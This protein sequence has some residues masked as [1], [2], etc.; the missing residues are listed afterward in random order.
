MRSPLS[1]LPVGPV[2][3]AALAV[4]AS[5]ACGNHAPPA[6]GPGGGSGPA[7]D[8][9]RVQLPPAAPSAAPVPAGPLA[10]DPSTLVVH[11]EV[12]LAAVR[13]NLEAKV[14]RRVAEEK[15][16][17]IGA[18]GRLEYT[19]DRGPFTASIQGDALVLETPLHGHARACA[20]GRCYAGCDPEMKAVAR[21]PLRLGADYKFRPSAVRVDVVRGCEVRALGGLVTVDAT[22][23]LRSKL[24]QESRRIEQQIDREL[25]DLRPEAERLWGALGKVQTLPLGACA[26]VRPEGVVQGPPGGTA[27]LARLRFGLIARPEMRARCGEAPKAA[28]LPALRDEPSLPDAGEV[29][30]ASSLATEAP[31]IAVET[32]VT[33]VD[34]GRG[35]ARARR[36]SG[37][38]SALVVGLGGD[39]CGDLAVG[40]A[41]AA[42]TDDAKAVHLVGVTP[43]AGEAERAAPGGVDPAA[44]ARAVERAP[45]PVALGPAELK[46]LVP[47]LV[48]G[49]SDDRVVV[50]AAIAEARPGPAGVRGGD[51]VAVV[52]ARGSLTVRAK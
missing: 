48:K 30:I 37:G 2:P 40:A 19:V 12:P 33:D 41:G 6:T 23:A 13:S 45:I 10:I 8:T 29:S 38:A 49:L 43:L 1:T 5:A 42:W 47:D 11:V 20:K 17:D 16:H 34:L 24:A 44:L 52:R 39:V 32:S 35:H 21:V 25:P 15:D 9:C 31:G 46:T 4:L 7:A 27:D 26:V 22:P 3:L 14:G 51:V 28:P 36:T 18:A 50:S